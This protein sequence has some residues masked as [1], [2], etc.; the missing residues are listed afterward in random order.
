MAAAA[1]MKVVPLAAAAAG[2]YF[3]ARRAKANEEDDDDDVTPV[4][5]PRP[6]TGPSGQITVAGPPGSPEAMYEKNT[7][8]RTFTMYDTR[9]AQN[10][11]VS[12]RYY[13]PEA[14]KIVWAMLN[15]ANATS[16]QTVRAANGGQWYL[17]ELIG[18]SPDV[19][20][21]KAANV[22][23][24]AVT[25]G[26]AIAVSINIMQGYQNN[27]VLMAAIPMQDR[28]AF[29]RIGEPWAIAIHKS[30]PDIETQILRRGGGGVPAQPAPQYPQ[31]PQQQQPPPV[32]YPQQPQQQQ[33]APQYP[34]Q[35]QQQQPAP[36]QPQQQQPAPQYPQQLPQYPQQLPQ[37][38][39]L[40]NQQ[41]QPPAQPVPI[42]VP[43][44]VPY[45]QQ[46]P[47]PVPPPPPPPPAPTDIYAGMPASIK[48]EVQG[49]LTD[50][51]M[52]PEVLITAAKALDAHFP[53]AAAALRAKAEVL[54]VKVQL[55]D[56]K[57]GGIPYKLRTGDWQPEKLA[58]WYTGS[59]SGGFDGEKSRWKEL[60]PLN[61]SL[62][63]TATGI[64]G[65]NA[66]TT[67]LMPLDWKVRT[68]PVPALPTQK[69][70]NIVPDAKASTATASA[71]Q[72]AKQSTTP[73]EKEDPAKVTA[74]AAVNAAQEVA[75][76]LGERADTLDDPGD[77]GDLAKEAQ[78]GADKARAAYQKG[79]LATATKEAQRAIDAEGK[80]AKLSTSDAET[81]SLRRPAKKPAKG[82][83]A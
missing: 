7:Y 32:Q 31:A 23:L 9:N 78:D 2:T 44:P 19:G 57:R 26:Y 14:A 59:L 76:R 46:Q 54:L 43:I 15:Q 74:R 60:L 20:E 80:A 75:D 36:Q 5:A 71:K 55:E 25:A 11:L 33:P 27:R 30:D 4:P 34:Q 29:G 21:W 18:D 3:L 83:A 61:K 39:P 51:N 16:Y 52:G 6:Q 42:P 35:P 73:S 40:P 65:W 69:A 49:L 63:S 10:A 50:D 82:S 47:A 8:D 37:F 58:E 72:P 41:Q 67:I 28:N 48:T 53:L 24:S 70:V 64:E 79:D 38:P 45:P 77:L 56:T 68:K 62:R 22:A 66:G 17:Y 13:T 12:T 1:M 81:A